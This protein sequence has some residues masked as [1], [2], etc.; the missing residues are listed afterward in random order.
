MLL[1][2]RWSEGV[3]PEKKNLPL[4]EYHFKWLPLLRSTS[5]PC[6]LAILISCAKSFEVVSL[7]IQ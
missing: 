4:G 1:I 3:L 5:Q 6:F 2:A 7:V